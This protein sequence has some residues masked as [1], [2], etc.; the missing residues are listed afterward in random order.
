M[1]TAIA[2]IRVS[3]QKQGRS[4]LGIEAQLAA[5]AQFAA[6]FGFEIVDTYIEVETGKGADA[7]D[8][9]PQLA[10]ALEVARLTG[11]TVVG[12]KLDRITRNVHFGSGLFGRTDIAFKIADMPHADNFQLNIMLAVAQL[13][14]EMI[15]NR[16]K[17]ALQAAKERGTKLGS[18]TSP[19]IL[20][21]R[22]TA[23]AEG[24][25]AIVMPMRGQSSRAIAAALNDR[26][27]KTPKGGSWSSVTALRLVNRLEITA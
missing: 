17:A 16:T 25:R 6:N 3:D 24:L 21:D 19:A 10:T 22:S 11:A 15:S 14:A 26:G 20:R 7:L 8:K 13:E 18:P 2:Y 1:K 5:V 27:I 12:A 23:F 4:G 9:R